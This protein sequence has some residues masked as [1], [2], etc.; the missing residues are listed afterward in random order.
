MWSYHRNPNWDW[1]NAGADGLAGLVILACVVVAAVAITLLVLLF[2][3]LGRIYIEHAFKRTRT[4]SVLWAN[5]AGL[6]LLLLVAAAIGSSRAMAGAGGVLASAA[7]CGFLIVAEGCDCYEKRFEHQE[8]KA[9]GELDTYLDFA[10]DAQQAGDGD[11]NGRK[12][13]RTTR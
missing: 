12:P 1:E 5:L 13:V 8:H 10:A 9:L 2:R 11:R 7:W 6:V 4:A 3:E